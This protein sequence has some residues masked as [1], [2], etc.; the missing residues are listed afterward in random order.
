MPTLLRNWSA[1]HCDGQAFEA[2]EIRDHFHLVGNV[3][4]RE[5]DDPVFTSLVVKA[6]GRLVT[7]RS[8]S[9]YELG[10]PDHE[11]LA[12]LAEHGK[13]IDL[14]QPVKVAGGGRGAG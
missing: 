10:K 7:T 12:W 14:D 3:D 11:Y 2:P 9:V 13:T 4:G 5:D 8:G 6:E 1:K